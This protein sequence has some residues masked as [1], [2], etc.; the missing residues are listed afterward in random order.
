MYRS[1]KPTESVN[2]I[3]QLHLISIYIKR[4]LQ[5]TIAKKKK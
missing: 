4:T 2:V 3:N 1:T 5:P